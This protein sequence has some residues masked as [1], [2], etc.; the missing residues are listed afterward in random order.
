MRYIYI[1]LGAFNG[2]TIQRFLDGEMDC[3]YPVLS[4]EFEIYGFEPNP[5]LFILLSK[6]YKDNNNIYLSNK[7]VY[8][9]S[10]TIDFYIDPSSTSP[11]GSTAIKSKGTE[12][13]GRVIQAECFDFSEWIKQ[14]KGCYIFVKMDI[15]GAEFEVLEKMKIDGTDK[16]INELL[17]ETHPNKCREYTTTYSNALI[18]S[19]QCGKVNNHR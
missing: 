8:T 13:N 3:D 18:N 15:E 4:K 19:L 17:V 10:D 2:D 9:N 12:L 1:D 14:F 5:K 7:L 11:M 6:Q 16:M